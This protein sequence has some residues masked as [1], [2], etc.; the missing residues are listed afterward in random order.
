MTLKCNMQISKCISV[1]FVYF[2]EQNFHI[3]HFSMVVLH[4]EH[5]GAWKNMNLRLWNWNK[6]LMQSR[7]HLYPD[8]E[9]IMWIIAHARIRLNRKINELEKGVWSARAHTHTHT[10]DAIAPSVYMISN[11]LSD[12]IFALSS[13]RARAYEKNVYFNLNRFKRNTHKNL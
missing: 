2:I 5:T 3:H 1:R 10:L 12:D 6:S 4:C 13:E 11:I 7:R 8:K 9:I